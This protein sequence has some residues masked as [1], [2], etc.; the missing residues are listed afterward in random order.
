ME[1]GE[2][3]SV[4]FLPVLVALLL[5]QSVPAPEVP[6]PH[7]PDSRPLGGRI[8]PP[9]GFQRT[10]LTPGSFG[11]FLRALP[12]KAGRPAVRLHNGALKSRQDVHAA[13]LDIDVGERDL[14]QCADAV[15]RLRAEY[16]W[17]AGRRDDI[18][19]RFTSGD[20]ASWA[21]WVGGWR[22]SVRGS[23]VNW[24]RS[25]VP[26]DSYASFRNYL[27]KMFEYAGSLSLSRELRPVW[28]TEI[29]APGDVFIQGGSPGHAV[30]VVDAAERPGG[31]DRVFLLAQSY[32][33]AQEIHVLK[34]PDDPGLGPWFRFPE[35]GALAT[36]EWT[37]RREDLKRFPE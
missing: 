27:N 18:R 29:P 28:R 11:A 31:R 19:F 21:R 22:P 34:N 17:A 14:Q 2:G 3:R 1:R 23:T 25:A 16:L 37:F 4:R 35:S 10:I 24:S 20:E 8:D 32:M 33:P 7:S 9:D 12:V 6:W 26:D 30:I 13:V 5:Q 15:I 36:P